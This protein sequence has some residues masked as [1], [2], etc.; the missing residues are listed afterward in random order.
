MSLS[1]FSVVTCQVLVVVDVAAGGCGGGAGASW[2]ALG[3]T[4]NRNQKNAGGG[5][6]GG[7]SASPP[8]RSLQGMHCR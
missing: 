7:R 1:L 5:L 8:M 3:A 2:C 6:G 4:L